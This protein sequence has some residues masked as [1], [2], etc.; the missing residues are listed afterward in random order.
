MRKYDI[1]VMG[2]TGFTG[3]LV[4]EY[5]VARGLGNLRLALA[6]RDPDKL[7]RLRSSLAQIDPAAAKIPLLLADSFNRASLV[8]IAASTK[9]LCTTVGPYAK[10]GEQTVAACAAL[11]THYCDI[12]GEPQFVR[13]MHDRSLRC[14]GPSHRRANRHLLRVRLDPLGHRDIHVV[15]GL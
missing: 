6:G 1:V 9:V 8:E 2:A 10:Y 13:R 15:P 5:L 12:S 11:G 7:E 4:A 14:R 3:S